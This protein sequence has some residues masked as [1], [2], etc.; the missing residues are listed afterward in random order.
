MKEDKFTKKEEK[1]P[2]LIY[3]FCITK[4]VISIFYQLD[5]LV[6]SSGPNFQNGEPL[7]F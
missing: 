6:N 1:T 4:K 3:I 7:F 5:G 2:D